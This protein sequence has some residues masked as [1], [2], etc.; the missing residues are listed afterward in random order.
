M[1]HE[2]RI[3]LFRP[4]DARALAQ[5]F[6]EAARA[7]APQF[8]RP[9]QAAAW[10][11]APVPHEQFLARVSDG[12]RVFVAVDQRDAPWG[13]IELAQ[14]GHIDCFYCHP[15]RAGTGVGSLLYAHLAVEAVAMGLTRLRVE[16]SEAARR[17][18]EHRG[19]TLI[20]RQDFMR[21]GVPIHNYA[22]V[23]CLSRHEVAP[24]RTG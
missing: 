3:R 14:D 7:T 4:A 1:K 9:Q 13:F 10:S 6:H 2:L 15:S 8:Y 18:F 12:R 21:L 17:F 11:P 16:A 19:F 20:G 24:Q 22:M 23:K 5:I